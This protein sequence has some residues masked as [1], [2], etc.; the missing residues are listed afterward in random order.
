VVKAA[1]SAEPAEPTDP[2]GTNDPTVPG[3]GYA[4]P[5]NVQADTQQEGNN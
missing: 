2:A 1:P 3:G 5:D 4:D